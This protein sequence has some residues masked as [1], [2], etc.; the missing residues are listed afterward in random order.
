VL[1]SHRDSKH[2]NLE[3]IRGVRWWHIAA[4]V[5]RAV[6]VGHLQDVFS[7]HAN[8]MDLPLIRDTMT[9][10]PW[11]QEATGHMYGLA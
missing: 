1:F 9:H 7:Y 10:G 4:N 11:G 5:L 2:V 8:F 3:V 6:N